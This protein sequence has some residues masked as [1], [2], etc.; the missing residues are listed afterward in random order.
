MKKIIFLLIAITLIGCTS[1]NDKASNEAPLTKEAF[2]TPLDSNVWKALSGNQFKNANE[3]FLAYEKEKKMY[4]SQLH[5][6]NT[7][8]MWHKALFNYSKDL[9]IEQVNVIL[10][11][12]DSMEFNSVSFRTYYRLLYH[13]NKE[14]T[15]YRSKV[16]D[17]YKKNINYLTSADWK[18]VELKE[19]IIKNLNKEHFVFK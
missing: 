14:I 15:N 2:K 7:M 3:V 11:D 18:N 6:D 19:Q 16:N 5:F 13:H 8:S 9:K 1:E 4:N 10:N 17:F 12:M